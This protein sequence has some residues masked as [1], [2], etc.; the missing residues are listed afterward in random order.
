MEDHADRIVLTISVRILI[1]EGNHKIIEVIHSLR[2]FQ[3][4]FVDP[5]SSDPQHRSIVNR[6]VDKRDS[7]Y[8]ALIA[9]GFKCRCPLSLCPGH[10]LVRCILFENFT[11]ISVDQIGLGKECKLRGIYDHEIRY[12]SGRDRDGFFLLGIVSR[13]CCIP[14]PVNVDIGLFLLL[15]IV[16]AVQHIFLFEISHDRRGDLE[17]GCQCNRLIVFK[18]RICLLSRRALL[19]RLRFCCRGCTAGIFTAASSREGTDHRSN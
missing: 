10:Q 15:C 4:E 8:F 9:C 2:H 5:V 17:I 13:I 6:C 3:A 16:V 1:T 11:D 7:N 14:E 19:C 12:I 18:T